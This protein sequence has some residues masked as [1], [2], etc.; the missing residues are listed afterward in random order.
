MLSDPQAMRYRPEGTCLNP[1]SNGIC[2]LTDMEI[3]E[4]KD[5][6]CLNPCSNGICSLTQRSTLWCLRYYRL[7]PC[8]N[9][10]CSLT[11]GKIFKKLNCNVLILVLMEYAL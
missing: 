10:I 3:I 4:V 7:N 1:C 6:V 8:S 9:G 2:S 5:V 11:H